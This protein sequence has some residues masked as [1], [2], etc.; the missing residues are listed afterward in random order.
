MTLQKT[1]RQAGLHFKGQGP[2]SATQSIAVLIGFFVCLL[3]FVL[4]QFE[5]RFDGIQYRFSIFKCI[6]Y[7]MR[8][9]NAL[10]D[11]PLTS[12]V[13]SAAVLLL[14][15][16][17]CL[18]FLQRKHALAGI[19]LAMSAVAG[20]ALPLSLSM[21]AS[22]IQRA[23]VQDATLQHTAFFYGF[24]IA[25][26]LSSALQFWLA[27][28]E[29]FAQTLF[30][31]CACIS[32]ASVVLITLY[33]I[34]QGTPAIANIGLF[35]FL[36]G[37]EWAPTHST[38]PQFGILPMILA[39]L[40]MTAGAILIGVP[41]GLLTAVFLAEL[42]PRWV[43][44]IVRPAVDLL[45]GIPSVIYGFF[46]MMLIVPA[47]KKVFDPNGQKGIFGFSLLSA[48]LILGI[49]IL[50][51]IIRTTETGLRAVPDAYREASL[52]M[53]ATPISTIFKVVIPAAR[54]SILSGVIL[55]V[56]RA[57]GETMAVIMVA[58]NAVRMPEL[59]K[60]VRPL[61]VGIV[62]EMSYSYGLHKQ[63]LFAIGLVLFVFIMLTNL[64]F[65]WI[66]KRG[67]QMHEK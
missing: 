32:I 30:L 26:F 24:V 42:A 56:G 45:G 6:F 25:A 21:M 8:F 16:A 46:G 61:T 15:V 40:A 4:P 59:L 39:S 47:V 33:M 27:G 53:G 14:L 13:I 35:K 19:F 41:I 5:F 54:S 17:A 64:T 37:T 12:R 31:L 2:K 36:F 55:G 38:Q 3:A 18:C 62:M 65:T 51:I 10:I 7:K 34:L 58:G 48:I 50:P 1:E 44:R 63:A 28:A 67:V 66:S 11:L 52:A 57:I 22:G 49:M 60:P 43:T 29:R 23:G 20:I 9:E